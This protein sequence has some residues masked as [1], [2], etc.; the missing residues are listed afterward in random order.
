MKLHLACGDIYLDGWV[1]IDINDEGRSFLASE[2]KDLLETRL[3][4]VI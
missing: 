3:Y 2:K 1:N 4:K